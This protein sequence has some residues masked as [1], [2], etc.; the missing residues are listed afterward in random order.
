MNIGRMDNYI[1]LKSPTETSST[2][3]AGITTTYPTSTY[4]CWASRVQ[5]QSTEITEGAQLVLA[6][7]YEYVIRYYDA[8][9]LTAKYTL[10]DGSDTFEIM[11]IKRI[12]RLQG[13]IITATK[14]DNG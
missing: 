4:N 9:N 11:G 7:T 8:P 1:T 12:D 2:D 3:T 5:K 14:R 6:D 13:W 10:V